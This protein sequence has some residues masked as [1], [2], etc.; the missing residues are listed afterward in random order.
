MLQYLKIHH[1][2]MSPISLFRSL[3]VILSPKPHIRFNCRQ[4][5]SAYIFWCYHSNQRDTMGTCASPYL[6]LCIVG[7]PEYPA[8][9]SFLVSCR[10]L[11]DTGLTLNARNVPLAAEVY[12][13]ACSPSVPISRIKALQSNTQTQPQNFCSMACR[14]CLLCMHQLIGCRL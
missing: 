12:A 8:K 1:S 6:V 7:H 5:D 10:K 14:P 13:D 3:K 11:C 4:R 2:A 9:S